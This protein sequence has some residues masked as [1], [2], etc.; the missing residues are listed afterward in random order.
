MWDRHLSQDQSWGQI[1]FNLL[2]H[3]ANVLKTKFNAVVIY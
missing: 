2:L 1:F 3:Q